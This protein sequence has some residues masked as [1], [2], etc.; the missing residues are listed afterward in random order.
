MANE[1]CPDTDGDGDGL[2][3][4]LDN[5][6]KEPGT[7]E[8][9]G[10]PAKQLV[11]MTEENIEILQSVYFKTNLAV[12]EKRSYA[13]LD[14]VATV[15]ASH[16]KLKIEVE[17]H[18]DDRGDEASNKDLSQRRADAVVKYLVAK[19]TDASRLSAIGFGEEQP[20]A[21]NTTKSGRA[22]NRRVIFRILKGGE[23]FKVI[24]QGADASTTD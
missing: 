9:Q 5:C 19:G 14:N 10:C 2:V 16:P 7:A 4:R 13:L 18:T 17:G 23:R 1:G 24:Q 3:D 6:P 12:I 8:N 21:D 15:M 22:S 11:S 20:I